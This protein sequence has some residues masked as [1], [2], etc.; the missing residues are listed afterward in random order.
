MVFNL[1]TS[2]LDIIRKTCALEEIVYAR[3]V[4]FSDKLTNRVWGYKRTFDKTQTWGK[5]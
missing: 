1:F 5:T 3:F 2:D 4:K